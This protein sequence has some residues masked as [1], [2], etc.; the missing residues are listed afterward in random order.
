MLTAVAFLYP[1]NRIVGGQGVALICRYVELKDIGLGNALQ[2]TDTVDRCV[3]CMGEK[4]TY[5]GPFLGR[6][7]TEYGERVVRFASL[8]RG[9]RIRQPS[10]H[11]LA[12]T[13]RL[14]RGCLQ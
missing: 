1:S 10:R 3:L 5:D 13:V 7:R 6:L 11:W 14:A 12:R 2:V 4:G 8:Q 9:Q